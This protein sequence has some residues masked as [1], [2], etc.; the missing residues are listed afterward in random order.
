MKYLCIKDIRSGRYEEICF[1]K[2]TVYE[3]EI[4]TNSIHSCERDEEGTTTNYGNPKLWR[5]LQ[6]QHLN[7]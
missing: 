3:F 6:P 7:H 1:Y 5:V 2:G 4:G